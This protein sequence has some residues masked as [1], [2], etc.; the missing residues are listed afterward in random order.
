MF[1]LPALHAQQTPVTSPTDETEEDIVELSPFTVDTTADKGYRATNSISGSR[2]ST[3]IKEIPMPI[4]VI[5][6]DFLKDVGA[7]DLR[8][9]LRYSAG[10]VLQSQNTQGVNAFYGPGGVNNPESVTADKNQT[11]IKLRGYVTDVVLRDGFRR[12]SATD[13]I[14]IG[15]IEVVRGPAALLYGIGNFGGIVNYLPKL[16]SL[17]AETTL[18]AAIGTDGFIRGTFDTTG[19][20]GD[21]WEAAYRVTGAAQKTGNY[22]ELYDENHVFISPSVSFKP[23]EKTD[24]LVD[25]E[26]GQREETGVGFLSV[27]ARSDINGVDQADRLQS[28]GFVQ[29]DGK[30][31][32]TFRWSGPDT[33]RESEQFNLR[34]QLTQQITD[35]LNLLAGYNTSSVIFEGRDVNGA[36]EQNIG[37]VA[38]RDTIRVVPIDSANGSSEFIE[39]ETPNTIFKYNWT[40]NYELAER[41]QARVELNY[42]FDLFEDSKWLGLESSVLV[43]RSYEKAERLTRLTRTKDTFFN[44]KSPTDTSYIR[45][46][47]QGDGSADVDMVRINHVDSTGRNTGDYAVY[48]GKWLDGRLSFVGGVRRD[49]NDF[50]VEQDTFY[51]TQDSTSTRRP[52]QKED[53][54][55][56]GVTLRVLPQ[57]SVYALKSEGLQPNFDGLRD[58]AGDPLGPVKAESEEIGLKVDFLDGKI[59]GTVSAFTIERKGVPFG[60]W[61]MPTLKGNFDESRPIIYNVGNFSPASAP[62]G[63]NGGNG[64]ADAAIAQWD[65]GVAAGSIYQYEVNGTTS[66][67]VNA[68]EA[69]GAAYLDQVFNLTKTTHPG[70]AGW[71]YTEDAHTN[72]SF[73]DIGNAGGWQAYVQ[74]EDESKGWDAQLLF[75]PTDNFQFL[76]S[77]AHVE[78]EITNPGRFIEYPHPD[79]RWAVWFFPDGN[80]GLTGY[81]LDE[82]YTDPNDTSTWTGIGWGAGESRDDTPE[83]AVSSWANYSFDEG[84]LAG[85]TIGLGGQWESE[86]EYFSGITVAGQKQTDGNGN[87]IVLKHK[88]RLNLDLMARYDFDLNNREAYVQL[89]INNLLNDEDLYGLIYAPGMSG[90]VEFGYRF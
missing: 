9:S 59:S 90:R 6:E 40:D 76:V 35:N 60:Q 56:Y 2:I 26:Y 74:Q 82:V 43:G 73:N 14:N 8:E 48:Q 79:N 88:S 49:R 71:L 85:L 25:L 47:T 50:G 12:Q 10:V 87:L 78:R 65:A 66:W 89:N 77:Y 16:P 24:V 33:F 55:Q 80:W 67:Y 37:P 27:R 75:T 39:T 84:P 81:S 83:H 13:S 34:L 44:Y 17:E 54:A 62:G 5:T 1:L 69:T 20:L 57:L 30:D 19:P 36:M 7:T 11:T 4:E 61:W 86:R 53:T 3:A 72:N 70:W 23:F 64:A 31:P 21:K 22:T 68:S 29:F 46:G 38:L 63:S 52:V 32:R 18:A 51:P 15:R 45:F 42:Q 41:E 58:A 28:S